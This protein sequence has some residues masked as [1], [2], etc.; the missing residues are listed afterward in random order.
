MLT[1]DQIRTM[2]RAGIQFG[3]HTMSHPVVSR[4][5]EAELHWELLEAKKIL[6][7]RL[8][9][10][11]HHFA[12]PF[13]KL[14]ECGARAF[15][16]LSAAGYRSAATTEWGLNSPGANPYYLRRVQIGEMGTLARFAFEL[17]RLFL[18]GDSGHLALAPSPSI[19]QGKTDLQ[20]MGV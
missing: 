8:D 3:A 10:P 18:N 1:W 16:I 2:R 5:S 7:E 15:P 14:E 4:L 6:Q 20:P 11:V 17:H 12:F 13:G 9:E 19:E